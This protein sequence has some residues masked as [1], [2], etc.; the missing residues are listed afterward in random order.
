MAAYH[1]HADGGRTP[2]RQLRGRHLFCPSLLSDVLRRI[3]ERPIVFRHTE[4][5]LDCPGVGQVGAGS[6]CGITQAVAAPCERQG[7]GAPQYLKRDLAVLPCWK[8]GQLGIPPP[9]VAKGAETGR[10]STTTTTT[11]ALGQALPARRQRVTSSIRV[12]SQSASC[13][14]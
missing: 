5:K 6:A 13:F 3:G 9:I 1:R 10:N 4:P 2:C 7:D 12:G 14:S 8:K 11:T